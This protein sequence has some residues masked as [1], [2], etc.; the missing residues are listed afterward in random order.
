MNKILIYS[1]LFLLSCASNSTLK[2]HPFQEKQKGTHHFGRIDTSGFTALKATNFDWITLVPW[3]FQKEHNDPEVGHHRGDSAR[4]KSRNTRLLTTMQLLHDEGFKVFIKPHIWIHDDPNGKWRSDIYPNNE[5]DWET[6]KTSYQEFMIRYAKLAEEGKAEMFC[7]GTELTRLSLEKSEYWEE[8]IKEIRQI[9]SGKITYAANWYEEYENITFWEQ[10]DYIGIQAYFPLT[11]N[12]NPTVNEISNGWNQ[13]LPHMESISKKY[14][15]SILFTEI[16]YKG[17]S[18]SAVQPWQWL[19]D[20][21]DSTFR[22][23]LETQANAY[24]AFFKT[25]WNQPWFSGAHLW[26]WR[27]DFDGADGYGGLD[28]TPQGKPAQQVIEKG[29]E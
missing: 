29:F 21:R 10:L 2:N 22:L 18:D 23:S 8:L 20:P 17:T 3:G 11:K 28:F 14:K 5:S 27:T 25:V 24:E 26:Q 19:D 4:I 16:G 9:Y 6:W 13:F 15:R 12:E 7:I 1:L